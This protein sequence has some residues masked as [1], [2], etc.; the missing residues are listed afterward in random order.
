MRSSPHREVKWRCTAAA[1][2]CSPRTAPFKPPAPSP[3][4]SAASFFAKTPS[5]A[6]TEAPT[7]PA[8][9]VCRTSRKTPRGNS[10]GSTPLCAST[11][12]GRSRCSATRTLGRATSCVSRRT[13]SGTWTS[14][15]IQSE[16]SPTS[17]SGYATP[18]R[19]GSVDTSRFPRS[20]TTTRTG[21]YRR[22]RDRNSRSRWTCR[23]TTCRSTPTSIVDR[24]IA[25]RRLPRRRKRNLPPTRCARSSR[26]CSR[27][28]ASSWTS[29]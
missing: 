18:S 13:A 9:G 2:R 1:T 3:V 24:S 12:N 14:A 20:T 6:S 22:D 8:P 21:P 15:A 23:S 7:C 28:T 10:R 27:R 16:T 19:N 4:C 26:R 29:P 11:R 17:S 25:T 5:R